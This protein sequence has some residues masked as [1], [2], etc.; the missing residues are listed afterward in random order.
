MLQSELWHVFWMTIL[1]I[2]LGFEMASFI[3]KDGQFLLPS[4]A[5]LG[6][7]QASVCMCLSYKISHNFI[8]LVLEN[9]QQ[10]KYESASL[11]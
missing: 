8:Y 3:L 11:Q 5:W 7:W 1:H 6:L 9:A 2:S 4:V 10:E